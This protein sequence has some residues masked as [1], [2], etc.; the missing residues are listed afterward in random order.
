[1]SRLKSASAVLALISI[2]QVTGTATAADEP[3]RTAGD[4]SVDIEHLRLDLE[5]DLK[6]RSVEGTATL[7]FTP[8]R[9]LRSGP[10]KP[11][12]Q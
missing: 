7:D 12:R 3:L 9:K 11:R 1:M 6:N 8:M 2:I 10:G 5:V 4:R